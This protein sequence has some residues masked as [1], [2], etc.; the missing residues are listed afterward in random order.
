MEQRGHGAHV[1]PDEGVEMAAY[2]TFIPGYPNYY[3]PQYTQ[4]AQP[5]QMPQQVQTIQ[6]G[7]FISV[8]RVEVAF[9]WP[10]APGNSVMFKDENAP[11]VYTK[12]RGFSQLDEPIFEKYRLVKEEGNATQ[13]PPK[14]PEPEYKADIAALWDEINMLKADLAA[15]KAPERPQKRRGKDDTTEPNE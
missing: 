2:N 4:Y 11:Y 7:G 8:P 10:V 15:I 14:A 12:T 13:E 1:L 6:N 3:Q 9:N 5:Q